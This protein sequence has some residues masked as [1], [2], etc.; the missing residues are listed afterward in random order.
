MMYWAKYM[1]MGMAM[2][3]EM[4]SSKRWPKRWPTQ[5]VGFVLQM[6]LPLWLQIRTLPPPPGG[7]RR[8][9]LFVPCTQTPINRRPWGIVTYGLWLFNWIGCLAA[10]SLVF[11]FKHYIIFMYELGI[12]KICL[13]K[14]VLIEIE[15]ASH[16]K[17]LRGESL[18]GGA[19]SGAFCVG[20]WRRGERCSLKLIGSRL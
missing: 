5:R 17:E 15:N 18:A 14:S 20:T 7:A 10:L 12:L 6:P 2:Q 1:S 11:W 8:M 9:V 13:L 4:P 19:V 3:W 16:T